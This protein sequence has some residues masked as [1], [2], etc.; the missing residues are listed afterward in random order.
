V[1]DLLNKGKDLTSIIREAMPL[2]NNKIWEWE[3][4]NLDHTHQLIRGNLK[5]LKENLHYYKLVMKF[6]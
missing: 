3:I 1:G 4:V 5:G 2:D 6:T